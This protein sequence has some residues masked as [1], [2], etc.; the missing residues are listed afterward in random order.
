VSCAEHVLAARTANGE[1]AARDLRLVELERDGTIVA[2]DDHIRVG[3]P[4]K[5]VSNVL[6]SIGSFLKTDY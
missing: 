5:A 4:G 3:D 2:A 1:V 6:G